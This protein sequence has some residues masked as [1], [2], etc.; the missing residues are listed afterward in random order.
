MRECPASYQ[1]FRLAALASGFCAARKV[2]SV[3]FPQHVDCYCEKTIT[4]RPNKRG[5]MYGKKIPPFS[6]VRTSLENTAQR[7]VLF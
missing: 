2:L 4:N 3:S 1:L 7:T 6:N 5:N